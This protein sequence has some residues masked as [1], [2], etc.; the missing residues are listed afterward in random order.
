MCVRAF[1]CVCVFVL[2]YSIHSGSGVGVLPHY[3]LHGELYATP[4]SESKRA[5]ERARE[6]I[7]REYVCIYAIESI[8]CASATTIPA[9]HLSLY[10][11]FLCL[12]LYIDSLPLMESLYLP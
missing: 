10:I 12:I 8:P 11:D 6:S 7:M 4:E 2:A 5:S 3:L 9:Q 1:M